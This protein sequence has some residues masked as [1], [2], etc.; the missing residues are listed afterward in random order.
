MLACLLTL[1]AC[2][3]TVPQQISVSACPAVTRCILPLTAP[4]TNGELAAS[5]IENRSALERCAAEVDA[6]AN[7]K[8]QP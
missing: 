3:T 2:S 5:L 8:G 4:T 6:I 1:P 7:I